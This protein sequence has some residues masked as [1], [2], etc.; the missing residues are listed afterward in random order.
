M[1]ERQLPELAAGKGDRLFLGIAVC[2]YRDSGWQRLEGA[3]KGVDEL[4]EV[5][6]ADGY[7]ASVV[8]DP[9]REE[10][11]GVL[12]QGGSLREAGFT[13]PAVLVWSGHGDALGESLA[14]IAR[15]TPASVAGKENISVSP[16]GLVSFLSESGSRDSLVI[17]DAC[18]AGAGDADLLAAH[19]K[20][21]EGSTWPD[22]DPLLACVVSCKGYERARDGG[23]VSELVELLRH[24]PIGLEPGDFDVMWGRQRKT[25][26]I[27]AVLEAVERKAR[28]G[29]DPGQHP[30]AWCSPSS[31]IGFRNPLFD[32]Q[33]DPGLVDDSVRAV[34]GQ[35]PQSA[36]LV[37]TPASVALAQRIAERRPG[38]WVLTGGPGAGKSSCLAQAAS[39]LPGQVLELWAGSGL[40]RLSRQVAEAPAELALALDALDEAPANELDGLLDLATAS[41]S[42]RFVVVST[43]GSESAAVAERVIDVG[44]SQWRGDAIRR[45]VAERL[46]RE[47]ED[48]DEERGRDDA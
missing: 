1:G 37:E 16:Q 40:A 24:G 18:S 20:K 44:S 35:S 33:A 11:V 43:R 4:R 32:E 27:A 17:I 15:D 12:M 25:V 21:L 38:L 45:Y 8:N 31:K 7:V 5:L 9:T 19:I 23:F 10:M 22:G 47:L 14:L 39:A 28:G 41:A 13:G 42:R 36:G 6:D 26:P 34:R 48:E 2:E 29:S 3:R 46:A 30:R